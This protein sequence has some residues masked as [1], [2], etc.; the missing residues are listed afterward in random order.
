MST[1]YPPSTPPG[2]PGG[3][4]PPRNHALL[5]VAVG[6]LVV[7]VL[8]LGFG[9]FIVHRFVS[10]TQIVT[11]G[12]GADQTTSIHSP[13]GNLRVQKDGDRARVNIETP[14]GNVRV[15]PTP[16][17]SRLDMTIYPGAT[18]VLS[19]ASGSPFDG[20]DFSFDGDNS[21]HVEHPNVEVFLQ[22]GGGSLVINV[23]EF[24]T[25]APAAQ[26]V[27]YYESRLSRLGTVERRYQGAR[28]TLRL[29]LS[30]SN[31]RDVS[32]ERGRDATYFVLVRVQSGSAA[33]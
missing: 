16:D 11:T 15:V 29:K 24:R 9:V 2:G 4:P 22:G 17:L 20:H 18:Q 5:G 7:L 28:E 8:I 27:S 6:I 1:P 19:G 31:A 26:V 14:F 33:R 12:Q 23:A 25:P 3:G 21:M 30:D 10:R 13:L 32:V